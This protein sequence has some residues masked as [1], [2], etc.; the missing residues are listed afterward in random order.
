LRASKVN[1]NDDL[2]GSG[3]GTEAAG[4][5]KLHGVLVISEIAFS[6]M[7]FI[8]AALLMKSFLRLQAVSPGFDRENVLVARLSLPPAKYRD[9]ETVA[10]FFDKALAQILTLPG[11]QA[12]GAVNVLPLSGMNTRSDFTIAGRPPLKP[13]DKPA[14]QSRWITPDYFRALGV[15]LVKGREFT[16]HDNATGAPV[17]IIDEA[18]V[19]R[20]WPDSNPLGNHL[21]IEDDGPRIRDVEIVGVVETVKHFSLDEEALPTFY[22]PMAQLVP[23]QVGFVAGNCSLAVRTTQN[24]LTLQEQI[25]HAVQNVPFS[26]PKTMEQVLSAS[27]AARRF[28]LLL[29]GIFSGAALLLAVTG[30]YAVI[31]YSVM[32]RQQEIGIRIALGAQASDVFKLVV[33]YGIRLVVIGVGIGLVGALLSTRLVSTLLFGVSAIDPLMFVTGSALLIIVAIAASFLPA[34]KAARVDPVVALRAQ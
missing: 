15:R 7:L 19:R 5:D 24:P 11:V 4:R 26:N 14:A 3:K 8:T 9:R 32:R 18:L 22:A 10:T 28:N 2:A 12:A 17:A 21:L 1:L 33:G 31:S 25:R 13:T 27:V 29:L 23:G 6:L 16:L 20:H 34:R 30:V